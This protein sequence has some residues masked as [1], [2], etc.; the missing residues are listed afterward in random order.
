MLP[1]NAD[2]MELAAAALSGKLASKEGRKLNVRES[3][4]V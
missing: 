2:A 1:A 4:R 3:K